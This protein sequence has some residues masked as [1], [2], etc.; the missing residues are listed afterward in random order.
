MF[1]LTV[2]VVEILGQVFRQVASEPP[3]VV[4]G[5]SRAAVVLIETNATVTPYSAK[6]EKVGEHSA[7]NRNVN[8]IPVSLR[9]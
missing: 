2:I 7:R 9:M 4:P 1:A 6:L 3:R 5:F 8:V